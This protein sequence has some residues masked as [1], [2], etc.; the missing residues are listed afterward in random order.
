MRTLVFPSVSHFAR[1][2]RNFL[3]QL[4]GQPTSFSQFALQHLSRL[5]LK[6][7]FTPAL[8]WW[9]SD[10]Q[11]QVGWCGSC[12]QGA[13]ILPGVWQVLW[14][15]GRR[16]SIII[17]CPWDQWGDSILP[18]SLSIHFVVKV[19]SPV[20]FDSGFCLPWVPGVA[21][22]YDGGGSGHLLDG[23][24]LCCVV[25]CVVLMLLTISVWSCVCNT[26]KLH[27]HLKSFMWFHQNFEFLLWSCLLWSLHVLLWSCLLLWGHCLW[28][29]LWNLFLWNYL[30]LPVANELA[31]IIFQ[32]SRNFLVVSVYRMLACQPV[33]RVFLFLAQ[34]N[35]AWPSHGILLQQG[36]AANPSLQRVGLCETWCVKSFSKEILGDYLTH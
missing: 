36:R 20:V 4:G 6:P 19:S 24:V 11:P 28:N 14:L 15:L 31:C 9:E 2:N 34:Q 13:E 23:L 26:E 17:P 7:R 1:W 33:H 18:L 30:A 27:R 25:L 21:F 12:D 16:L 8:G 32:V 29:L 22:L 10:C 5:F 3:P 35:S